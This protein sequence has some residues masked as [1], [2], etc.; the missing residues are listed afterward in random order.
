MQILV[1]YDIRNDRQRL[2][3]C[4]TCLDYGLDRR[5]FSVFDGDLSAR[6]I[7]ALGKEL[8]HSLK[9]EGY[10][11]IVPIAADDWDK[12]LEIGSPLHEH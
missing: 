1:I 6:Q 10:I 9:D 7:H 11:L 12:R 4:D 2:K 3:V 5:Q 8:K